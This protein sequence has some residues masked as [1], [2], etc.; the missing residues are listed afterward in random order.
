MFPII[1][2]IVDNPFDK[3]NPDIGV[4]GL[5]GEKGLAIL[6]G[7]WGAGLLA[8]AVWL[9]VGIVKF[10]RAKHVNRNPAALEDATKQVLYPVIAIAG[11]AGAGTIFGVA[12][13]LIG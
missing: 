10:G 8:S 12:T 5:L 4:W 7:I 1:F 2:P 9:V 11:L 3:T 6:G 13:K